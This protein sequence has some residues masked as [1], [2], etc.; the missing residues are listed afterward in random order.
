MS[1]KILRNHVDKKNVT[2]PISPIWR[3]RASAVL[4]NVLL[5]HTK[6]HT[7][8]VLHNNSV[9]TVFFRQVDSEFVQHFACVAGQAAK[10]RTVAVHYDETKLAVVSKQCRQCLHT[11]QHVTSS[12]TTVV[13]HEEGVYYPR[14]KGKD[15]HTH[16]NM[17][18][19]SKSRSNG[20]AGS[21]TNRRCIVGWGVCLLYTSPSPR[22]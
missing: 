4:R 14:G 20:N 1:L 7:V 15:T 8:L 12:L 13:V 6:C 10:Q 18:W 22:D 2:H 16:T 5:S 21:W 9:I 3:L 17:C 19:H 11:R